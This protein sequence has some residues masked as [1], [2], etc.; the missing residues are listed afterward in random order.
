MRSDGGR[1]A[2]RRLV[3]K[4]AIQVAKHAQRILT[5]RFRNESGNLSLMSHEH[6]LFLV[7][8]EII[9]NCAEVAGDVGDGQRLHNVQTI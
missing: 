2:F 8:L 4:R 9:E 1:P 5:R 6:D 3:V 7:A